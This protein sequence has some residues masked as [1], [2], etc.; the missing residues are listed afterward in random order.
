MMLFF[1]AG[2]YLFARGILAQ[3]YAHNRL[4]THNEEEST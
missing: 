3:G 4:R 2:I 1:V